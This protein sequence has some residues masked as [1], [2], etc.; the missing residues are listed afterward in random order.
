MREASHFQ[1]S[2]VDAPSLVNY[3]MNCS[4]TEFFEYLLS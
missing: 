1:Q 2:G 4:F 3:L